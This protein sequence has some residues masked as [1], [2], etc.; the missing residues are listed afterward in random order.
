[1]VHGFVHVFFFLLYRNI[2]PFRKDFN[3]F[4]HRAGFGLTVI[5]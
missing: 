5:E 3:T 1:V 2:H 4:H